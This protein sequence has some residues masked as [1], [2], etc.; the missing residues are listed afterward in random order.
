MIT[1]ALRSIGVPIHPLQPKNKAPKALQWQKIDTVTTFEPGDNI[2]LRA[3]FPIG[4]YN[5]CYT[6]VLDSDIPW[7][8]DP[9][10]KA[11]RSKEISAFVDKC[12]FIY[13]RSGGQHHGI[14][15]IFASSLPFN[16]QKNPLDYD[17]TLM[18]LNESYD[19]SNVVIAPSIVVDQYQVYDFDSQEYTSDESVII[20]QWQAVRNNPISEWRWL[21]I[22]RDVLK[23][24]KKHIFVNAFIPLIMSDDFSYDFFGRIL[25]AIAIESVI[26][27]E[28][29][30]DWTGALFKLLIGA[31]E[32]TVTKI[33]D[34]QAQTPG[35][36]R[37][38]K[39]PGI[40][41]LK[42]SLRKQLPIQ[43]GY[44]D[45]VKIER[46]CNFYADLIVE[47]FGYGIPKKTSSINIDN[48]L[49]IAIKNS[50]VVEIR[51]EGLTLE[52]FL[53]EGALVMIYGTEGSAKT[54]LCMWLANAMAEGYDFWGGRYT[55]REPVPVLY[56]MGD[57]SRVDFRYKYI[58]R[59][60]YKSDKVQYFYTKNFPSDCLK[61]NIEPIDFDL[62]E[63]ESIKLLKRMIEYGKYKIIIIDTLA[64]CLINIK[65]KDEDRIKLL[66]R[67]LRS[68]AI[69]YNC[70]IIFQ[71]HPNKM[72]SKETR[73]QLLGLDDYQGSKI[74][75]ALSDFTI[76]I[77]RD[78]KEQTRGYVRIG[79]SGSLPSFE[80]FNYKIINKQWR[81]EEGKHHTVD[82]EITDSDT[83]AAFFGS[84]VELYKQRILLAINDHPNIIGTKL[85]ELLDVGMDDLTPSKYKLY[86]FELRKAGYI[87]TDGNTKNAQYIITDTGKEFL[88]KIST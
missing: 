61:N 42:E 19:C 9:E 16:S 41:S 64:S 60:V 68:I 79:K 86:T 73:G 75:S 71:H 11:K 22:V 72:N 50:D 66:M 37:D 83:E 31:D 70:I 13:E 67:A 65:L 17:L 56:V 53:W 10:I 57:R 87:T 14:H 7:D 80:P 47:L 58:N 15:V 12:S 30:I 28:E 54:F 82:I 45:T 49:Q 34:F 1:D 35:R 38:D 55:C 46:A 26:K 76:S 88:S 81:D 44:D 6:A 27:I 4:K 2:G 85:R 74:L 77:T 78:A 24:D 48:L 25:S 8:A 23:W 29:L 18:A 20:S 84:K 52:E 5:D 32:K 69:E 59:L 63:D 62:A 43:R 36:V 51:K 21:T 33:L 39:W 40:P 3:G